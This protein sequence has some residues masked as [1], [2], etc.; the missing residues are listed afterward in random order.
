MV[1]CENRFD[2]S[3]CSRHWKQETILLVELK[4][5]IGAEAKIQF[6]EPG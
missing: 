5:G 2:G 3:D 1:I 6:P 4:F